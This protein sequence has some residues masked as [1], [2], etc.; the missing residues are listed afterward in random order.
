MLCNTERNDI[1]FFVRKAKGHNREH[2]FGNSK[3]KRFIF[4]NNCLALLKKL[5][6][7]ISPT[8]LQKLCYNE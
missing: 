1:T 8:D 3:A 5:N 6:D 7:Y 2:H 4:M